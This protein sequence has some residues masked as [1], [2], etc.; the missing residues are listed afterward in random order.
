MILKPKFSRRR[1][2]RLTPWINEAEERGVQVVCVVTDAPNSNRSS[3]VCVDPLVNGRMAGELMG[4]IL[5]SGSQVAVVTGML[6][7]EEHHRKVEGFSVV[8]P[9]VC[10][11]ATIV[12]ILE[13]H[14]DEDETFLKCVELFR[15]FPKLSGLYV[16]TVNSLPVCRALK[17]GGLAGKIKLITTDLFREM[18]SYFE[19]GTIAA[20]IYQ[21]PYVQGQAAVRLVMDNL[22]SGIPM[23]PA[24]HLNPNIVLRSNLALFREMQDSEPPDATGIL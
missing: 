4:R 5:P 10:T 8:L 1:P 22:V 17:N 23:L 16:S 7:T 24:F 19:K 9:Q 20:S 13:G 2:N 11:G 6:Q 14:E 12:Q 18:V 3:V 21:H 15:R